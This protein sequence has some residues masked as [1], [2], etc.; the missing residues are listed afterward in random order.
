MKDTPYG[1]LVVRLD[2]GQPDVDRSLS[3]LKDRG[4]EVEVIA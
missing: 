2:G 1:Q 3:A 4:L